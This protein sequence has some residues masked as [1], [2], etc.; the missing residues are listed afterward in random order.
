ME[1]TIRLSH[2]S[3]KGL[4]ALLAEVVIPALNIES[5]APME[6]AAVLTDLDGS[7]A[8]TTDS[9]VVQPLEF[10][11]GDIGKLAA[12]GTINDLAMMGAVPKYLSVSLICEEGLEMDRLKQILNSLK[13]VCE[14][15]NVQIVCGDT[16]VVDRGH[17]DGVF[18]NTTGIGVIRPNCSLSAGNAKDG[19]VVLVSG[20]IGLHGV[21]IL[22]QRQNLGF[23][24][25]AISDCAPLDEL[26]RLILDA[27]P[28]TRVLRDATRGGCA[29]VLN[30]I[31]DSSKVTIECM[32][33]D[34][35]V[36]KV[37]ESACDYLG[38]DP[39]H[40][41]NEGRFIAVVPASQA[42]A[43]LAA[44]H[45][46]PLGQGAAQIGTVAA[47]Q[48]FGVTLETEIGGVRPV[49]IPPGRLLPRIC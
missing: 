5:D 10:P 43:A 26:S 48:R 31:A 37:V 17:G 4:A 28:D 16:K 41:A 13:T 23:A 19:D 36:P 9:F 3:G 21:T 35:P 14:E 29:A 7:V 8:F 45:S 15:Q 25:S 27:A 6:D 24:S 22:A 40:I 20:P 1:S 34:I 12:C 49:E 18:I 11:G 44:L 47:R 42:K 33:A 30:E 46:H 38:M 39:L 2:G 32:K